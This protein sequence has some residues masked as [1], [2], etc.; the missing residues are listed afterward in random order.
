MEKRHLLFIVLSTLVLVVWYY[1]FPPQEVPPPASHTQTATKPETASPDTN[2][3]TSNQPPVTSSPLPPEQPSTNAPPAPERLIKV[4]TPYWRATF[5]TR[6]A[7]PVSWT[8]KKNYAGL[9]PLIR[10]ADGK[11]LE[12]ITQS[13]DVLD[14]LG[15]PLELVTSDQQ[16]NQTLKSHTYAVSQSAETMELGESDSH[17]LIF[18]LQANGLE[19]VKRF[20]FRGNRYDFE[21]AVTVR[22]NGQPL[23][24]QIVLGPNFGDQSV[25]ELGGYI[26]GPSVVA[27]VNGVVERVDASNTSVQQMTGQINWISADDNYFA[28]ALILAQPVAQASIRHTTQ[29]VNING[30]ETPKPII[31][32]LTPIPQQI[33]HRMFVGP[34]DH[35]ILA[36][37]GR[38]LKNPSLEHLIRYGFMTSIIKPIVV[39]FLIPVM[40]LA[41][42]LTHNYGVAI[43]LITFVINMLFFPLKWKGAIKMRQA[44]AMQP[45]M[46]ELQ[47]QMKRL[48]KDDPKLKEL[49]ME[50]IRLMR[51][52]NPLGGCLPLLVQLPFFWAFFVLLTVSIDV[53]HAPFFGWINNLSQPDTVSLF[54]FDMH[55]LPIL[56]CLSMMAQTFVMPPPPVAP[57]DPAQ[58]AQQKIQKIMMGVLMPVLFTFLFFWKAPSGLV[59]YWMFSNIVATAQQLVINRMIQASAEQTQT[60]L[61]PK[62]TEAAS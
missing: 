9:R 20:V 19:V 8:I 7:V 44:Q 34:K 12:L 6:G 31:A 38:E 45:K 17:V 3:S 39:G 61:E 43:L 2:L 25:T 27:D 46:K 26:A 42:K 18:S 32:T 33:T 54:G 23:D 37:L 51:Q 60:T 24:T 48:K 50:Q 53:R 56:M 1:L 21:Y 14:K 55:V 62:Q 52:A 30:T 29:M 59:L 15:A 4:Q 13:R 40:N 10:G 22:Q 36:E 57:D 49:Q 41:Y 47:N 58:V 5:T 16:I 35:K 28:L 11:E